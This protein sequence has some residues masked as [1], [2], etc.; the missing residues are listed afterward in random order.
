MLAVLERWRQAPGVLDDAVV[1]ERDPHLQAVRHAGP[2]PLGER[3]VHQRPQQGEVAHAIDGIGDDV[4]VLRSLP[5]HRVLVRRADQRRRPRGR[6]VELGIELADAAAAAHDAGDLLHLVREQLGPAPNP[7]PG[8]DIGCRRILQFRTSIEAPWSAEGQQDPY[9][10]ERVFPAPWNSVRPLVAHSVA[11]NP[12]SDERTTIAVDFFDPLM[13]KVSPKAGTRGKAA[14]RLR[15]AVCHRH[16]RSAAPESE[17]G[18]R[19]RVTSRQWPL[20]R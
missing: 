16:M 20:P 6:A 14:A 8:R 1:E 13:M 4:A 19:D 17:G 9:L 15:G 18:D 12:V 2:V 10:L 5:A 3:A 11:S 7:R